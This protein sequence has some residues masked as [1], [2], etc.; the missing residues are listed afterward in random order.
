MS[1]LEQLKEEN[2]QLREENRLL[3]LQIEEL[4]QKFFKK[5]TP[6]PEDDDKTPH[7]PRKR[8]APEGHPGKTR[9]VPDHFDEHV[10][11]KLS[12]CPE[13]GCHSLSECKRHEDHYQ[14]DIVLP[15][16]KVTRF[17]HHF[18]WCPDCHEVVHGIGEGELP[19]SYIGPVA[20]S[21][22][23]FL[24]Y[25]L[26]LPYRKIQM[27]FRDLFHM[28]FT[29]GAVPGFDRQACCR[30]DPI[31]NNMLKSLPA[32]RYVH[33]DETG[34]R[35]EGINHW[36]WCFIA[37]GYALYHIDRSR[38]SKVV[39]A[40][41]GKRYAGTLISDFLGAYNRIRCR[42]QRC[43]VHLLRLIKKWLVY[44][45][46]DR[47]R[48]KYFDGLKSL[49]KSIIR[50]SE[51][52]ARGRVKNFVVRKADLVAR[53]RRTLNVSLDH[54][55]ADKFIRKLAGKRNQLVACLDS[56]DVCAHNNIAERLLR[57]NVIMRKI[58]FGNRSL[59]GSGQH[60]HEVLMSLIQTARIQN[61]N[62]LEFLRLLL[63]QPASASAALRPALASGR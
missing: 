14:E 54:P 30:G 5:N 21:L 6:K 26:K 2:T 19:G 62:P 17:R 33:A 53:L 41:M 49:V 45:A 34:W 46:D 50:L 7:L 55:R 32:Q 13:C 31:Y 28:S 27:L 24:H 9:P 29:P 37:K 57:D 36:L 60:N 42:K 39:T 59:T 12:Q 48:R 18:Y 44:F 4:R 38:G 63:T 8:G 43:L 20:K 10:D 35:N 51:Q 25:Q 3:K 11:V 40:I 23:S 22:A 47:K 52:Y 61:L 15:Q 56:R 16:V 1:E 58:T